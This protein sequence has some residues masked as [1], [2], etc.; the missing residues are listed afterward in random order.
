M[1]RD[2]CVQNDFKLTIE[3]IKTQRGLKLS[4]FACQ[5]IKS[6]LF[7]TYLLEAVMPLVG[8]QGGL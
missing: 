7:S 8:G 1:K 5:I 4:Q 3:H 2:D 6:I